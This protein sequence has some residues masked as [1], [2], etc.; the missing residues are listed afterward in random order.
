VHAGI[1]TRSKVNIHYI[2]SEEIERRHG[3][4]GKAMDAILVPGGF[5]KRGTEG[6]IAA[7]RYARENKVPYLGICLGMQLATIEFARHVAGL[8][9]AN[10]T[11]FDADTP[12]PVVGADHRVAG[13]RRPVEKRDEFRPRRHHAPRRPALPDQAGHAGGAIYGAGRSTSA[14]AIATRSTTPT[15]PSWKPPAW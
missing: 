1:H 12:H 3:A 15:C 8:D 11:E 4:A 6:K 10:S 13:S 9:G 2:D 5:G 7:I 14:I